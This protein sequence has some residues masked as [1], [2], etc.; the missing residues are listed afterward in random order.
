M[1]SKA[2]PGD[3]LKIEVETET[4]EIFHAMVEVVDNSDGGLDWL[5]DPEVEKIEI[6][7]HERPTYNPIG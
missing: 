3:R 5:D 6:V 4:G 7:R 2:M 1:Q